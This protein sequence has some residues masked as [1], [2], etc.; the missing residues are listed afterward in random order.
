MPLADRYLA[1]LEASLA[2]TGFGGSLHL[3]QSSGG[4]MSAA[5]ARRRPLA[6]AV[7]GPAGG[8]AATGF[9]TRALGLR[10]AIAFDMGGTTT[11]AC[12]IADGRADTTR[13]RRLG[14]YPVRL[15][16]VGVESIGAGGGSLV[17][18]DA[19]GLRVGPASAGAHPGPACYG[20]GG[21]APTVTDAHVGV[22]TLR[23]D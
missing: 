20:L 12:L 3:L 14:G 17:R 16:S 23:P 13:E 8:V 18:V 5:V 2:R 21:A 19:G 15:R 7:S 9:L 1:D 6:M 4:M 22:G 10:H 11:D